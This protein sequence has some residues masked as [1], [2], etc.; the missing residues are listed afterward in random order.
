MEVVP[1]RA[2]NRLEW[3]RGEQQHVPRLA[4]RA[5]CDLVHSLG[6]HR[7]AA[8]PR[9]A[10]HDHPRPQL[11]QGAGRP[12]RRCAGSACACS[13]RPRRGARAGSSS[14]PPST[15]DDL[16]RRP[17]RGAG[18][19]I[20]VVPLGVSAPRPAVPA[21]PPRGRASAGPR[22]ERQV[23]LSVSAKRPHKNLE[24]L[25]RAL[26]G[27][28]RIER[29]PLAGRARL[30][31]AARGASCGRW[32]ARSGVEDGRALAGLG[33]GGGARGLYA[34]ATC[35][36]FPSLYEGFGLPVLEAMARGVPV[37]CSDRA[38]L[39]RSPGDAALLF[40][41]EDVARDQRGASSACS[42]TP[43]SGAARAAGRERAAEL[44]LGADGRAHGG[45]L[46][47][48]AAPGASL[49]A[50]MLGGRPPAM[51]A[52]GDPA[53][54]Q[55]LAL[56]RMWR[57]LSELPRE[58]G[59]LLPRPRRRTRTLRDPH[60]AGGRR[61][62]A[63]SARDDMWTVNEVFCRHDYGR[64]PR[65]AHGRRHRLE[66]R[67]QRAVLPHPQSA[68]PC[69]AATSRCR[70]TSSACASNLAGLRI[71]TTLTEAAVG[72]AGRAASASASRPTAATAGSAW[73]PAARSRSTCVGINDGA[74]GGA[75]RRS[76]VVDV[77]KIDTEGTEL[78]I[79][80]AIRP[81]CSAACAP[82][83]L[84][85]DERPG[86]APTSFDS[87]FRNE[88]WVLR[89]RALAAVHLARVGARDPLERGLEREPPGVARRTTRRSSAQSASPPASTRT[90][91]AARSSGRPTRRRSRSRRPR[92]LDRGVVGAARR[93]RSACRR[94][95]PRPRSARSP[96]AARAAPCKPPGAA[97]PRPR[98]P[99]RTRAAR[100][101]PRGPLARRAPAPGRAPA[102][103][104]RSPPRTSWPRAPQ[105]GD[106]RDERRAPASP[107]C[108]A[109]R[110]RTHWLCRPWAPWLERA[111]VLAL[112]HLGSP[113]RPALDQPRCVQAREAE[114][115][116]GIRAQSA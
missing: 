66:H 50:R 112:E 108:G 53:R 27:D 82:L 98:L 86:S 97:R 49:H 64:R 83:Y 72:A 92:Q 23:V 74:R 80:E 16:V 5:G 114:A 79:A 42:R 44:H 31:D 51:V 77:L 63:C 11:R 9:A 101:R 10:R 87:A 102:R 35:L 47:A 33:V 17:R 68:L 43:S 28:L 111:G 41:P 37:A 36:V 2:R 32:R 22:G 91:A 12:L 46:R 67:H 84:E 89:N 59:A 113:R 7:A 52:Q 71:A 40:D 29:R 78:E 56:W 94:R 70:A 115:R 25:L 76:P 4:A 73:T 8:R 14:T 30:P 107:G 95:R 20:D 93:R 61:A 62:D 18:R 58:R 104:R 100:S 105:L 109:R 65:R 103:R 19:K 88:T 54:P 21:G 26:G 6:L 48:R 3:V 110:R 85:V 99:P 75:R 69:L 38:S 15:R 24:R 106:R 39:P 13:C 81:S 55:L 60:A 90:I 96:R 45:E 1:V 57:V 116:W 34:A